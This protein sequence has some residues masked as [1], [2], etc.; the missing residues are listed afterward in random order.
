MLFSM[1]KNRP[2]QQ[3]LDQV[4]NLCE[5]YSHLTLTLKLT[6]SFLAQRVENQCY[7]SVFLMLHQ[8]FHSLSTE[9]LLD[10]RF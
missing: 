2:Y 4:D 7:K 3:I 10:P 6:E 9:L 1:D 5:I 8:I